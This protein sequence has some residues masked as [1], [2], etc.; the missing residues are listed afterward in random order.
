MKV[1]HLST[2][3]VDGGAARGSLWLHEALRERGVDSAMMVGRKGSSGDDTILPL[4]GAL[5]QLNA[6]IRGRLDDLP[7]RRYDKTDDS[8]WS[9]GWIPARF[10][11]LVEDFAPDIVHLH[12]VGAGFLPISSLEQFNCPVV[13]TLRDMWGFTGGCHYTAGC[14]Q[15]R[16][17]CGT[18]PQLRSTREDDLSRS[19]WKQK[20]KHW[21]DLDLWLVPIS[22]WLGDCAR[23]SPLFANYPIE[24][25]PNGLDI[26]L[27][28]P[29]EKAAARRAWN[30][31]TDRQIIVYGAVNAT[32]DRR[33]G[34]PELLSALKLLGTTDRADNLLL[35]VFGDLQPDDIPSL[36]IETHFVGYV[37][38]NDRLSLLYSAADIA[39]MPSLQ[40]AFGKTLIE[41]MACRTPVVAFGAG[42]PIDIIKHRRNGYLATPHCPGDLAHGIAWCL[43]EVRQGNDLGGEARMTV[44]EEFDIEVV[45]DRYRAL[46]ER[47]LARAA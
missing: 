47:I 36:G 10:D 37:K 27:F 33:K 28:R 23:D 4:P 19:I 1:L 2:F 38:D 45:A 6:R 15:Y 12:W 21:Q 20:H 18:C 43:D 7:L 35:V 9:L 13:W 34:F 22:G 31:P 40:E 41:A 5:A 16:T 29:S 46:Y 17:G 42:G 14:E 39:V 44:E 26:D 11:R 3:D 32:Q 25:I 24:V 8:F 30:L